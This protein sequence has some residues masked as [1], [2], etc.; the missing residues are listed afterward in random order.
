MHVPRILVVCLVTATCARDAPVAPQPPTDRASAESAASVSDAERAALIDAMADAQA[1]LLTGLDEREPAI[2]A[3]ARRFA[4]LATSLAG[5]HSDGVTEHIAAARREL[6][7][8]GAEHAEQRLEL[9]AL[10]LVLDGV[11]AVI[12]GRVRLVPLDDVAPHPS[13]SAAAPSKRPTL[14]RSSP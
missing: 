9:A 2:E 7:A 3:I 8:L 13:P 1:W 5:T 6:D 12:A 11:E 14:E 10:G 4:A